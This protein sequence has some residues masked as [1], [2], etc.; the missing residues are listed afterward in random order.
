[1][2]FRPTS[3]LVRAVLLTVIPLACAVLFGRVDLAVLAAP[4]ALGTALALH[5]RPR[6]GAAVRL[7]GGEGRL[8]EGD[9]GTLE[10]AVTNNDEMA[11]DLVLAKVP[12]SPDV[13]IRYGGTTLALPSD[14]GRKTALTL[15]VE[16]ARWGRPRVDPCTV[17]AVSCD[18]LLV[19]TSVSSEPFRLKV[20]PR[21]EAFEADDAMPHAT[22]LVGVHRSRR[23]G[24]G[25]E[26]ADIRR[27]APGDRLRRID[28]RTS[29]RARELHVVQ[30]L[31]DR[32][33]D[34]AVVL[35]VLHDAGGVE[36]SP[37]TS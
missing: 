16:L 33:A 1:M 2:T 31:S 21:S 30:T 11:Y 37:R 22:G 27:Y 15:P 25:G 12:A 23:Y 35:D 8:L 7:T 10:L 18:G 20:Y 17:R 3:A 26:L 24:D 34:L 32:D 14:G 4:F 6:A 29:L 36:G 13:V 9:T 28:W 5:R 19:S